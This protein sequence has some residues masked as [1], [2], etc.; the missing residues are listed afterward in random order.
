[1][2][3]DRDLEIARKYNEGATLRS[4]EKDFK[5]THERIRQILDRQGVKIRKQGRPRRAA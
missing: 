1:M 3:N 4:L 2:N 5:I